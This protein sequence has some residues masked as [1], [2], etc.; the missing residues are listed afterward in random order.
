M[1]SGFRPSEPIVIQN[2]ICPKCGHPMSI[3]RIEPD[4]PN[5]SK[6]TF[7]CAECGHSEGVVVKNR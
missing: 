4:I 2:L 6:R 1:A 3:V 7:E 5:H